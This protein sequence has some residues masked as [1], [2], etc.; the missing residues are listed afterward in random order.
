[1]ASNTSEKTTY[2]LP[3]LLWMTLKSMPHTVSW[4]SAESIFVL[5]ILFR[6]AISPDPAISTLRREPL[7][8]VKAVRITSTMSAA[9]SE[10][11]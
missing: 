4:S 2:S 11:S 8:P 5:S 1:M 10:S 7:L 6:A 9:F 3:N